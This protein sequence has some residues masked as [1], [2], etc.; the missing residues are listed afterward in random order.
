MAEDDNTKN[1]STNI[2]NDLDLVCQ[3][4]KVKDI[5]FKDNIFTIFTNPLNIYDE[6]VTYYG[7]NYQITINLANTEIKFF[8]DN[9]R[10]SYWTNHDPHPHVD[11]SS[12]DACLGNIGGTI[13]ELCN[14]SQL[15][16]LA[17]IC[18]D[19]LESTNTDDEAG[20]NIIHWD[21]IEPDGCIIPADIY[22]NPDG[23]CQCEVCDNYYNETF[24]AFGYIDDDGNGRDERQICQRCADDNYYW[25]DDIDAFVV[26]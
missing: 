22:S 14:Q 16:A 7:G 24:T 26:D 9:P 15:Y 18:I 19:F 23:E 4:D 21:I 2:I 13:A 12:G 5:V 20:K 25:N 1:I 11:G 6:G 10:P 3:L 17:L 8:G